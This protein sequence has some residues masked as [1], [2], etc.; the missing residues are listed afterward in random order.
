MIKEMAT[1]NHPPILQMK[2]YEL[3]CSTNSNEQKPIEAAQ[4]EKGTRIGRSHPRS[5]CMKSGTRTSPMSS[6]SKSS[7]ERE[8]LALSTPAVAAA[9]PPAATEATSCRHRSAT[10]SRVAAGASVRHSG[11]AVTSAEE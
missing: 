7:Q 5:G 6:S 1:N 2:C 8:A 11:K 9:S 4:M 10:R 3:T